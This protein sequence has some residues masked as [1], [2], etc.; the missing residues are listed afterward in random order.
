MIIL[1]GSEKVFIDGQQLKRGYDQD[2]IIDYNLAEITFTNRVIITQFTRIRVDY[3]FSDQNYSRFIVQAAHQ[4]EN[5]KVS[6]G[7]HYYSEKDNKAQPLAFD[8]SQEEKQ[9]LAMPE[10]ISSVLLLLE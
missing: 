6:F 9:V 3:E 2:Y 8:L 1:A 5:D 4:Q 10:M 7:L